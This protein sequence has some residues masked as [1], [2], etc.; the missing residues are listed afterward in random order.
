MP[1]HLIQIFKSKTPW[2]IKVGLKIVLS[3]IPVRAQRWQNWNLFKAGIMD[4]P[5]SAFCL[6][7]KHLAGARFGDLAGRTVL[8]LGPGNS[9]LT[10]LFAR[11]YGAQRTWLVDAE[12][13]ASQEIGLFARAEE[14]LRERGLP[15]PG[16]G[17]AASMNAAL[18]QLGAEYLTAGTASLQGI[19]DGQVDFLFSNAVLEHVRLAEFALV[20]REMHRVLKP[21]GVASHQIDF[22]DHLQEGLNNLRFSQTIWESNLM[23]GSGFYTNRL[24]WPAMN[25]IFQ[26]SGLSVEILATQRWPNGLPTPQ[27]SMAHPFKNLPA[28]QLMIMGAHVILRRN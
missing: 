27:G 25:Q 2:F 4:E 8:E 16:V 7:Q 12:D 10:A 1:S 19:A 15:V 20:A 23:A 17:T 24:P 13:L 3:R 22:R 21:D 28:E 14:L 6:F 5:A 26:D 11:A 18:Q 9:A